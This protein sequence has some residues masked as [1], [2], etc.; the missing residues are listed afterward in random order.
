[1]ERKGR[2]PNLRKP[3]TALVP[4]DAGLRNSRELAETGRGWVEKFLRALPAGQVFRLDE[5]A[6]A[7]QSEG[8]AQRWRGAS[9]ASF[10]RWV[11]VLAVVK[12]P[13]LVLQNDGRRIWVGSRGRVRR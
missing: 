6:E 12:P 7:F 5:M 11:R 1:M 9:V 4:V 8:R 10:Y 13:W 3:V 2:G